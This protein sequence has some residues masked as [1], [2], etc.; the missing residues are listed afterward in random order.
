ML[1]KTHCTVLMCRNFLGPP[2]LLRSHPIGRAVKIEPSDWSRWESRRCPPLSFVHLLPLYLPLITASM[3]LPPNPWDKNLLFFS[4]QEANMC[5]SLNLHRFAL[6]SNWE[7]Q[8]Q[9]SSQSLSGLP[10]FSTLLSDDPN[11]FRA[12]ILEKEANERVKPY[13][14]S[15]YRYQEILSCQW[16]CSFKNFHVFRDWPDTYTKVSSQ[17]LS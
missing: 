5:L 16:S 9:L 12:I 3:P 2:A 7:Q 13:S 14:L 1:F 17:K 11:Y 4:N 8:F 15:I 10:N 6:V